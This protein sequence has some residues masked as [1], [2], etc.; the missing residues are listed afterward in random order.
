VINEIDYDQV[1]ADAGGFVEIKNIGDAAVTLDGIVLVLVNGGDGQEYARSALSGSLAAG[2]YLIVDVDAQNG[3]PDGVALIDTATGE[4]KDA[5]SYEGA[6]NAAQIDGRTYDLV[7][8]T[9]LPETV[10]DSNTVDGSLSRIPDGE[11]RDD[12]A[13]DWEFTTTKTPGVANVATS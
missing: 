1:G 12:A 2:D 11:D 3:A 7:E 6:I 4:L 13:A 8:G 10:A 5:L 9:M